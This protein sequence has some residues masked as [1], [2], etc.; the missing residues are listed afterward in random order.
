MILVDDKK[1]RELG[2]SFDSADDI[3]SYIHSGLHAMNGDYGEVNDEHKE[4][5]FKCLVEVIDCLDYYA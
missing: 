5:W 2:W 4:R 1:M 3:V